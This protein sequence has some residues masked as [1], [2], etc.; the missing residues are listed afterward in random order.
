ML[1]CFLYFGIIESYALI[2]YEKER[3][4]VN[5]VCNYLR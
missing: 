4:K 3:K 2:I 1:N 5:R